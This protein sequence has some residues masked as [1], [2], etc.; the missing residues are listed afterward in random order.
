MIALVQLVC[1]ILRPDHSAEAGAMI[2]H[3]SARGLR[4]AQEEEE[5]PPRKGVEFSGA[6]GGGVAGKGSN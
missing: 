1:P 4:W 2:H 5:F 3:A 6:R